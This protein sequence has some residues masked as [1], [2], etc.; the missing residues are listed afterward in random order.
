MTDFRDIIRIV[1]AASSAS[2]V[3]DPALDQND[4]EITNTLRD[5]KKWRVKTYLNNNGGD[6]GVGSMDPVGY[7][8]ISLSSNKIIPISTNDEHRQGYD[9][10]YYLRDKKKKKIKIEDY[11]PVFFTGYVQIYNESEIKD[12]L[13]SPS[14]S[15]M[16][17]KMAF[18]TAIMTCAEKP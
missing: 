12:K 4:Y 18:C 14:F 5:V 13:S 9:L 6:T 2:F 10:L 15:A 17:V 16:A 1:E 11:R 8:M 7:V 3:L